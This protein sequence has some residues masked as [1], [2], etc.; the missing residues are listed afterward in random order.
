MVEEQLIRM[1]DKRLKDIFKKDKIFGG[2]SVI[3]VGDFYQLPPVHATSLT[4]C[5]S[6]DPFVEVLQVPLWHNFKYTYFWRNEDVAAYNMTAL[7]SISGDSVISLSSD[8][9]IGEGT[10]TGRRTILESVLRPTVKLSDTMGLAKRTPL[11]SRS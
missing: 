4:S 8:S 1:V 7:Q 9:A 6:A 11:E 2:I 5:K 10:T 3:A